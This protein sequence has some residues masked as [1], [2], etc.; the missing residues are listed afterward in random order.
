MVQ[1]V[2]QSGTPAVFK[3]VTADPIY[4][5]VAYAIE[6]RLQRRRWPAANRYADRHLQHR[7]KGTPTPVKPPDAKIKMSFNDARRMQ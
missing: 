2:K 1:A 6:R 5:A 7:G 3:G 4:V